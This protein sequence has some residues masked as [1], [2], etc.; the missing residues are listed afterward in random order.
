M[1]HYTGFE[2]F[3]PLTRDRREIV[4]IARKFSQKVQRVT[5]VKTMNLLLIVLS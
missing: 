3:K 1:L 2:V 5:A 4:L